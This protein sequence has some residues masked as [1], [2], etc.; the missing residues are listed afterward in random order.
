VRQ[1]G[2]VELTSPVWVKAQI[3]LIFPA[4]LESR[5]RECIVAKRCA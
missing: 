2:I 5:F 4:E 3:E 1:G